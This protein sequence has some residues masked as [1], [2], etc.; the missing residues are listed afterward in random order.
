MQWPN[1]GEIDILEGVND[2]KNN[3]MTLH[4]AKGVQLNA[5]GN[6]F[7][8]SVSTPNCDVNAPDQAKNAGCAIQDPSDLSYGTGFNDNGGG[9][10]AVE[11]TSDLIRMW[12]FPRGKFPDD[13]VNSQPSPN[14]D[15]GPPRSLFSGNF[16]L[17]DHFKDQNIVFD[18]TFCGQ[19]SLD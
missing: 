14:A 18:T 7:S 8:G 6:L 15:W 9:V 2:Q 10:F 19:V 12:F 5:A 13:I 3:L 1:N 11:W 16:N 17:D 4:S